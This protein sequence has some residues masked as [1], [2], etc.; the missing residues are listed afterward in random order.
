LNPRGGGKPLREWDYF[1]FPSTSGL[2]SQH[3]IDVLMPFL[4]HCF[5]PLPSVLEGERYYYLHTKRTIDALNIDQSDVLHSDSSIVLIKRY[6]FY[7]DRLAD[8][9][10]FSLPQFR[11]FLF[12]TE[13]IPGIVE[14]AGLRGFNFRFVDGAKS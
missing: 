4:D 7:R 11:P 5:V 1:Y 13:S 2:F 10:I 3:A 14:K 12:S 8:P 6:T 9:V